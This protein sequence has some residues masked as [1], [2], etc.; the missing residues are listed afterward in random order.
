MQKIGVLQLLLVAYNLTIRSEGSG[1]G[2]TERQGTMPCANTPDSSGKP[3]AP[4][5]LKVTPF[6]FVK[7]FIQKKSSFFMIK[8]YFLAKRCH[9]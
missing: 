9:L 2:K 3:T 4:I 1:E 8:S 7:L 5:F 6:V